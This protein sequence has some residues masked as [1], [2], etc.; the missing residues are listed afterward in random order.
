MDAGVPASVPDV[1][2]ASWPAAVVLSAS[3]AA[4]ESE[5]D[6]QAVSAMTA[7]SASAIILLF[8]LINL[9]L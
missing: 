9:L 2:S 8:F 3:D 7:A 4:G 5:L 1:L 6:E